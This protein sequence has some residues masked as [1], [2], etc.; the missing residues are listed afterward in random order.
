MD[1]P[2]LDAVELDI[3]MIQQIVEIN[4]AIKA[5]ES[6]D[7]P[8]IKNEILYLKNAQTVLFSKLKGREHKK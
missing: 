6:F 3:R 2:N 7:F 5:L 4:E 8:S 1:T